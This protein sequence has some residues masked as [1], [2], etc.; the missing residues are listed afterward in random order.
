MRNKAL[1]VAIAFIFSTSALADTYRYQVQ[2]N[3]VVKDS[4]QHDGELQKSRIKMVLE[5]SQISSQ[6]AAVRLRARICTSVGFVRFS[7][8]VALPTRFL[9]SIEFGDSFDNFSLSFSPG[10]MTA[11]DGKH[12]NQVVVAD[13]GINP[14]QA[15]RLG[16]R[17]NSVQWVY[18]EWRRNG[19]KVFGPVYLGISKAAKINARGFSGSHDIAASHIVINRNGKWVGGILNEVQ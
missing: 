11:I 16:F 5:P 3:R 15:T 9:N 19:S 4:C 1:F 8:R 14:R 18:L 10:L 6:I 7:P 12:A 13:A 2:T 17:S